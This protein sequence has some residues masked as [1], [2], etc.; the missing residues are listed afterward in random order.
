MKGINKMCTTT[1]SNQSNGSGIG[2]LIIIALIISIFIGGFIYFQNSDHATEKHGTDAELVRN[3][4]NNG[5]IKEI[6]Q[7]PK[8]NRIAKICK[9]EDNLFGVQVLD[10][11]DEI[12]ITAFIKNKMRYIDQIRNYLSNQGYVIK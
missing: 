5:G 10:E 9:I 4:C 7:N 6:W 3:S 11:N 2:I 12:E 1:Y 8:T